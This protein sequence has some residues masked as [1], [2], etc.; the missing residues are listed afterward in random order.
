MKSL[1]AHTAMLLVLAAGC[2][3][4]DTPGQGDFRV[5]GRPAMNAAIEKARATVKTFITALKSPIAG[6][7]GFTVKMAFTDGAHTEHMWLE[8]VTFDG[9]SFQGTV[10]NDPESVTT[11]KFGQHA[12]VEPSKISDWMFIEDR[13]LKGGY[14]LRVLRETLPPDERTEFDKSLPF[15]IE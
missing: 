3:R 4:G 12:S 10:K 1:L 2:G 15:V 5:R 7:S 6:Q 8:P 9:K 11:V 14:T 13:K